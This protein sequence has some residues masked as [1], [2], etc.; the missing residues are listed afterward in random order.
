MLGA[1]LLFTTRHD[2]DFHIGADPVALAE[3]RQA[4]GPGAWTWLSQVHGAGVVVVTEPGEHAGADGDAAVTDVPGAV[5]AV[6]TADCVPV[7]FH[8]QDRDVVG[9]AHVGWRGLLAGVLEATLDAMAAL[10]A[11]H[12]VAT[13]GPHIRP[14]CYEFGTEDLDSLAHRYGD[15]VRATTAWGTPGLDLAAGIR[16]ALR[17]RHEIGLVRAEPGCT[18]CEPDRFYS[19]RARGDA[20]RHAAIVGLRGAQP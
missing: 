18:A 6:H 2:G 12:V 10:G 14:R 3:R 16:A 19:H 7:L 1:S 5:L 11:V 4:L 9:A 20:G 15:V 8:G 13:I 17:D